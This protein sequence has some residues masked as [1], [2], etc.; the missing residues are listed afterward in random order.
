MYEAVIWF[1]PDMPKVTPLELLKATVPVL[2]DCVPA[3]S[4]TLG[5]VADAVTVEPA[6][7][8]VTLL[9]LEKTVAPGTV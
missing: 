8:K 3:D 4:R 5:A 9:L 7:P 1:E 6:R 2:T